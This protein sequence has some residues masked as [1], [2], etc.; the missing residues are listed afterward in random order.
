M[1]YFNKIF[2]IGLTF[3]FLLSHAGPPASHLEENAANPVRAAGVSPAVSSI[4]EGPK[5]EGDIFRLPKDF[6]IQKRS[7]SL[8]YYFDAF[9]KDNRP[10]GH[11]EEKKGWWLSESAEIKDANK[12]TVGSYRKTQKDS[13][14]QIEVFDKGKKIGTIIES[15]YLLTGLLM[16]QFTIKDAAGKKIAESEYTGWRGDALHLKDLKGK[17][18]LSVGK[19]LAKPG[20]ARWDVHVPPEG[21]LDSRILLMVAAHK[22]KEE[23]SRHRDQRYEKEMNKAYEATLPQLMDFY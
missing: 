11:V 1:G 22:V 2:F 16:T 15:H 9:G 19:E 14:I 3:P 23:I 12:K 20:A 4:P 10:L 8:A 6:E 7:Y 18:V 13:T 5:T 17:T 21:T